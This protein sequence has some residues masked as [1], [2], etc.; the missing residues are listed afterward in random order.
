MTVSDSPL[1][2]HNTKAISLAPGK[3]HNA[4]TVT[5]SQLR[6]TN[7]SLTDSRICDITLW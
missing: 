6:S 5:D 4:V 3:R 7:W 1:K 2:R